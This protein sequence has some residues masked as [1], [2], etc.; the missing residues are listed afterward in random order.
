MTLIDLLI[1]CLKD[2]GAY[3]IGQTLEAEEAQD[4][5]DI[6]NLVA[7]ELD[8]EGFWGFASIRENFTLATNQASYTWGVTT[9]ASDF[10]TARPVRVSNC[11]IRDGSSDY[12]V[13]ITIGQSQYEDIIDKSTTGRP[14]RAWISYTFPAITIYFYFTPDSDYTVYFDS[15]KDLIDF[16][17]LTATI[18]LPGPYLQALRWNLAINLCP[19]Y[20]RQPSPFMLQQAEGSLRVI[21]RLNAANK[22]Q[23]VRLN[24]PTVKPE[25]TQG[26]ILSF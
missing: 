26:T 21:K 13:D 17:T 9:P 4:A 1:I 11:F 22:A 25:G 18:N 20:K 15:E 12:P 3:N 10:T 5:V 23:P 2:I 19:S 7:N 6:L 24:L 16:S 14:E 8:D